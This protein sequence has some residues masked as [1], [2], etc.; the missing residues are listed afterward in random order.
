MVML[1]QRGITALMLAAEPG[2]EEIFDLLT[3]HNA[4]VMMKDW[5][6]FI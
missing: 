2:D 3:K 1:M 6:S 4:D 5:V